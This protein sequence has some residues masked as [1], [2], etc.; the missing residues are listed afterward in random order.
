MSNPTYEQ[1]TIKKM[2]APGVAITGR[3]TSILSEVIGVHNT[4]PP[5]LADGDF[6]QLQLDDL[7][8]LKMTFGDP[9][10]LD[11]LIGSGIFPIMPGWQRLFDYG[12][13][14]DSQVEYVGFSLMD[15][16]EGTSEWYVFKYTYDS[17]SPFN[18]NTKLE[19]AY[20]SWT[21]RA[22]LFS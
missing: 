16:A 14:T 10:I 12:A 5:S 22:A 18:R 2:K 11:Q 19:S 21:G 4:T 8:N 7:G 9:T 15:T 6:K 13:R 3:D 1:E 20:G 17:S